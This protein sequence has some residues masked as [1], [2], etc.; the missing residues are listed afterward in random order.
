MNLERIIAAMQHNG[1][2][3]HTRVQELNIVGIRSAQTK[4]N[5]FDDELNVFYMG[6]NGKWQHYVFQATT[7]PGTY[8]LNNP[9]N[10]AGTAL[11]KAGQYRDAYAIGMHRGKYLALVQA[12]PVTVYRDY[13]RDSVLDFTNTKT[14]TGMFG[15]NIHRALV[16]GTTK[17][18]DRHSAGCQVFANAGDFHKLMNLAEVHKTK[19]GN[20]FTYTLFDLRHIPP[21]AAEQARAGKPGNTGNPNWPLMLSLGAGI[22][23]IS[24]IYLTA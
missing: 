5:S 14:Q 9:M 2:H 10:P 7:D 15:I 20:R 4:A 17:Q 6:T 3:I 12:K 23:I 21:Q 13:N 24:I 11:L 18:I 8:W 16:A 1:Y 22:A 19:Y